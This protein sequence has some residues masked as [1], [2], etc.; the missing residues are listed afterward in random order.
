MIGVHPHCVQETSAPFIARPAHPIAE[1][2]NSS[3]QRVV[4]PE[5]MP[6][7]LP[8]LQSHPPVPSA[9]IF[10]SALPAHYSMKHHPHSYPQMEPGSAYMQDICQTPPND[11]A[12][13]SEVYGIPHANG[14]RTRHLSEQMKHFPYY[15][16]P[17][18]STP[19]FPTED[20]VRKTGIQQPLHLHQ[21]SFGRAVSSGGGTPGSASGTSSLVESP[22]LSQSL[23]SSSEGVYGIESQFNH[24]FDLGQMPSHGGQ[25]WQQRKGHSLDQSH[26]HPRHIPFHSETPATFPRTIDNPFFARECQPQTQSNTNDRTNPFLPFESPAQPLPHQPLPP[27]NYEHSQAPAVRR[28]ITMNQLPDRS[29]TP[30]PQASNVAQGVSMQPYHT[31]NSEVGGFSAQQ[32]PAVRSMHHSVHSLNHFDSGLVM[33]PSARSQWSTASSTVESLDPWMS[34]SNEVLSHHATHTRHS[35]SIAVQT[36]HSPDETTPSFAS[37]GKPQG[38]HV[39][40]VSR[41][42]A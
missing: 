42:S 15:I 1:E 20:R 39:S 37:K 11:A 17:R 32:H 41:L 26:R 18:A 13:Q 12:L 40:H 5:P 24:S 6:R 30:P 7:P 19:Q 28:L 25:Q 3:Q 8:N 16:V 22:S 14:G 36:D 9:P 38:L 33:L 21:Q 34:A 35:A 29:M 31:S 23:H 10:S 2:S 27:S 4:G